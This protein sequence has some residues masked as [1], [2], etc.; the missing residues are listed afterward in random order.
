MLTMTQLCRPRNWDE[1]QHYKNR[2]PPWI[3]L[4]RA[5]LDDRDYQRLP[6][7][8]R[9]LAPMLWLLASESE[10]GVFDASIEELT[11]RLRQPEKDIEAGLKALVSAGFFNLVHV[12]S[13][14]LA[15]CEHV[16]VPEERRKEKET[17]DL[18]VIFWADYPKKVA[19]PVAA[20]AFKSAKI[21]GQLIN[22]ILADIERRKS[23]DEWLKDGGK[24]IP[25]PATYLSQRRWED[26]IS[27]AQPERS[28]LLAG[29]I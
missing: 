2:R 17:D 29:A 6:L 10:E 22:I 14:V 27:V 13:S 24:Y 9:A 7:A 25:N 12:A 15:D 23:S 5:L 18:F 4:H 21:D 26:E 20:K 1:F 19:K 3:K 28:A 11:F 16:A 8:S